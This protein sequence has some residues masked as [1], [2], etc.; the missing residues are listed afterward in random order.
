MRGTH[1]PRQQQMEA[2][3]RLHAQGQKRSR[4]PMTAREQAY[5]DALTA[6]NAA[7][8]AWEANGKQ[9]RQPSYKDFEDSVN[10]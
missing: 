2:T 8:I 5:A 3:A 4:K 6:Y 9:G 7:R 10:W 1:Y